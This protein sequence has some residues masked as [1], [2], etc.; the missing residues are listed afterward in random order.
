M[1]LKLNFLSFYQ[2][3]KTL[4]IIPIFGGYTEDLEKVK[5]FQ[6]RFIIVSFLILLT[7][8]LS[9]QNA[10]IKGKIIN[11][12]GEPVN[13]ATIT[14]NSDKGMIVDSTGRFEIEI[15][16]NEKVTI[17]F[18]H[19][20]YQP[21]SYEIKLK[22]GEVENYTIRLNLITIQT[23]IITS[24]N[25]DISMINIDPS[26]VQFISTP[27]DPLMAL[28]KTAGL[29]IA[30]NNELSSGYSVRG[31]N[32]DENLIYVNDVEV[33]RPFL[34]RSGQQEGLSFINPD[35]VQS[36]SFSSG[37]FEAKYGDKMS[38]VLDITYRKPTKFGATVQAGLLG[39]NL[40]VEDAIFRN[41]FKYVIG[42]RYKSNNYILSS[43]DTK[44]DYKPDFLDFQSFLSY[45]VSEKFEINIMGSYSDN[46]YLVV[47][48]NR[49]T[50]FGHVQEAKQLNVYFDGKEITRF[51]VGSGALIFNYKPNHNSYYK[52]IAST[53][54]T[55]E[56][57][58]FDVLGQYYLGEIESDL[59]DP[60][61]GEV[62]NT[63]GVGS[64]LN[65]ARN[66]L[67]ATVIT[68]E[69]KS[70]IYIPSK[71]PYSR[72][73]MNIAWGVRYQHE[74]IDD[75]LDEW[76]LLDS[77]GY[78]LNYQGPFDTVPIVLDDIRKTKIH[79]SSNR[80]MAY[81]QHS[82]EWYV[83][84]HKIALTAGVRGQY[85]DLNN[86]FLFSPRVQ[87]S[88]KP[89]WKPD[90]VFRLSGGIYYQA[91]FYR[92]LRDLDG[93][94][95]TNVKAQRSIHAVLGMDYNFKIWNRPFKFITEVYYKHL[96]N[97]N[98]YEIDNVRIRYYAQNN[99]SGYAAGIDMKLAGELVEGLESWV[100]MSI[101]GTQED[102]E[103]DSYINNL[104]ETVTPGYIPRPTDQTFT[105]GMFFQDHI[106]KFKPIRVHLNFLFGS[107]L[108]FGPPNDNRYS[109]TL[110]A[111]FYRRVDIGFSYAI[112]Q[113][114]R[115]F[116]K[117]KSFMHHFKTL[118]V[119]FEV[120]N[121]F[122]INNTISY[123]WIRDIS[124]RQYAV[125]NYLTPRLFNL[126]VVA[127]F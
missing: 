110:R 89:N 25:R 81:Y 123:L 69:I 53:Y 41:R 111:P 40:H 78:L 33:Y 116:K 76:N 71:N 79:L 83:D 98:P 85:W 97:L 5:R 47:P 126:R 82:F 58:K 75:K 99:A 7:S 93:N 19:V 102:I 113:P 54:H 127:K 48:Q 18:R 105:F 107:K 90:M 106:P 64:F 36:L 12:S 56:S 28:L 65:H 73:N 122:D 95:N 60:N 52:F 44:G 94:I 124:N 62:V 51:Q 32:F 114:D 2:K 120:F 103:G 3:N 101:M 96:D 119:A 14:V 39:V 45:D 22:P 125:P 10:V 117:P 70:R 121:L 20:G 57:E 29:G 63:V 118:W 9:G 6:P 34:A 68:G 17:E 24:Q 80:A 46:N 84:S 88:W 4:T 59:S 66:K 74:I 67:E 61:F 42:F 30:T 23:Q 104:G 115:K 92:E 50:T 37:G 16:S 100:M 26:Q 91:P 86:E 13:Q 109:D 108:P 38:S 49:Q 31:G 15:P 8:V 77:S 11:E 72:N 35:M 43:L 27:G 55:Q 112:L 87:L 21:Q 1:N